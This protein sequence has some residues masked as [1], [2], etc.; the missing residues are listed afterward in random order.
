MLADVAFLSGGK[1]IAQRYG[2]RAAGEGIHSHDR[3]L[4]ELE[5]LVQGYVLANAAVLPW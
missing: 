3:E 4:I 1:A 5:A 2:S